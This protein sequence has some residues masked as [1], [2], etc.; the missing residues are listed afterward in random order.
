MTATGTFAVVTGGGTAGHVLPA[1]AILDGLVA[2]G[3][4]RST[5]RYVGAR[6]GVETDLVP[7]TGTPAEFLDVVGLQRRLAW[8]NLGFGP[9][10]WRAVR[11]SR[12][13]LD[14]W[15]PR[16]VVSVGGY[17]SLAMV[18]AARRR[19]I[20]VVVVSYDRR[21]GRSSQITARFATASAVAFADSPLP[22]AHHTGA[23]VR[24][25]ILAVDRSRDREQ[26]RAA[27]GWSQDAFVL[28]VMGGSQGSG[29]LNDAVL[30]LLERFGTD[31]DLV[32]H[33]IAGTR[34]LDEMT[35]R[36]PHGEGM[37]YD[38]VGFDPDMASVYAACDLLVARGGASTVVEVAV[39]GTPAILVPWAG[40][41]EA[42]QH[43]NVAW[44]VDQGGARTL[45]DHELDGLGDL[46]AEL[47][48]DPE[49]RDRLGAMAHE[50][51]EPH[52]RGDLITL[53]EEVANR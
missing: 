17:A 41:A 15:Q 37:L 3:H 53:I 7:P 50:A 31:R 13:L 29:A 11:A 43:A 28:A 22:R 39:T 42:H 45:E 47:R 4:D 35:A 32:V 9:K 6:R 8:S 19:S 48:A 38:V 2:R 34:F 40:A 36:A 5:L 49:G 25:E 18:V 10:L 51:G 14:Q 30:G 24:S 44:L 27:R 23:P 26:A 1:L 21:P 33:H 20:P 46:V 12:R 52:R 16:V